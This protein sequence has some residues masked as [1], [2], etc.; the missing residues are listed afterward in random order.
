MGYRRSGLALAQVWLAWMLMFGGMESCGPVM[1]AYAQTGIP[2]TTVTDTVYQGNGGVA[3]GTVLISWPAF[4]TYAGASVAAGSTSVTIGTGGALSV[5]LVANAGSTPMGS[6]YTVVYHL[7]DGT[8]T[9]EY[10]AVPV[11]ASAVAVS[12]IR[13]TVLPASVALQTVSK[14]YVDNA[15]AAVAGSGY[16]GAWSAGTTYTANQFVSYTDGNAYV[17]LV[18]SNIGNPP[19]T[20]GAQWAVFAARGNPG[21]NGIDS[22]PQLSSLLA[23]YPL[24][25]NVLDPSKLQPGYFLAA[26]AGTLAGGGSYTTLAVT[27]MMP[28]NAGGSMVTATALPA[29]GGNDTVSFYDQSGTYLSGLTSAV[30][31]GATIAI[32]AT[33][34]GVR[35]TISASDAGAAMVCFGTVLPGQYV[36]GGA[37]Y[38]TNVVDAKLASAISTAASAAAA[39]VFAVQP[40]GTN[41]FDPTQATTGGALETGLVGGNTIGAIDTSLGSAFMV[42]GFIPVLPGVTYNLRQPFAAGNPQYGVVWYNAS[43]VAIS[44]TPL[45]YPSPQNFTAPAGAAFVRFSDQ[46]ANAPT[47]M[48]T[49]GNTAPSSYVPFAQLPRVITQ[50]MVSALNGQA[51]GVWGDSI[52]SIFSQQWQNVVLARTGATLGFQDA[53][54]GRRFDTA[55]EC[56]G[57]VTPGAALGTYSS[58]STVAAEGGGSSY[59]FCNDPSFVHVGSTNGASLATELAGIKLMILR[60]GT[61]DQTITTGTLGDASSAGTLYGNMRWV[62]ENLLTANPQMRLVM[63]GPALNGFGTYAQVATV[64]AAEQAFANFYAIPYLSMLRNG[65]N[66]LVTNSTYTRDSSSPSYT[67][68]STGGTSNVTTSGMGT[69]PSDWAFQHVDGPAIAQFLL[70]WY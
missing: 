68:N 60:L 63:V 8:V 48:W 20:S 12:T 32:P 36:A 1:P 37:P 41:Y 43:R 38:A 19:A 66:N 61:N 13:T 57:T 34:A 70:Q 11:S 7:S 16:A 42:S 2:T 18:N 5:N 33:A 10:W 58:T 28:A 35:L 56:Y 30:A 24:N 9:R 64:D 40:Q 17:S 49:I 67:F 47:Q 44:A 45:P 6:Y 39:A 55:F 53:R 23:T 3:S 59:T 21:A 69:H 14:S 52:S 22:L 46:V 25:Q 50:A 15:I 4:S 54:P 65:G 51:I 26:G 62:I 27:G 31:A 29:L